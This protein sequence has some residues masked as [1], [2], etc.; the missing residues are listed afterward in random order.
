M[1][2][3]IKDG[4]GN[5]YKAKVDSSNRLHVDSIT[6]GRSELEVELGNGYNI[7]TGLVTLTTAN[8]S[9]VLYYKNNED[10]DIV[11]TSIIYT[12][13]NSN[14]NGDV[15]AT[16]IKNPTLG[17]VISD[18]I[19]CEM[20]AINRN[21]GSS[22]ELESDTFKGGEGKTFTNGEKVIE[23]ILQSAKR[24]VINVGDV[25]MPKGTTLGIDITPPTG[26]TSMDIEVALSVFVDT[27][28][29]I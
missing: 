26:N 8:K 20:P 21:F 6:F 24:E 14:S 15:L 4:A 17:T 7:N 13:G 29:D 9:G 11:I 5:G 1:A 10:I 18:A 27:L 28:K 2:E 12:V 23:S 16:V 25:V 22:K 19:D 3:E